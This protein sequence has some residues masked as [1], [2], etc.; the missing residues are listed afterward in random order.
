MLPGL[1]THG[2]L[3]IIS[4]SMFSGKTSKLIELYKK[5]TLCNIPVIVVNH[6]SDNRYSNTDLSTHD[7]Q[8]I[9]CLWANHL[10]ELDKNK[11]V[12]DSRVILINEAQFF[13]D[14][15]SWTKN[16][17]ENNKKIVF[18]CGLDGDYTRNS[19]GNWL[20]LIPLCDEVCKLTALC[21]ACKCNPG[22]F[23]KRLID[24]NEQVL[25]GNDSYIPVCR[26]CYNNPVTHYC[27]KISTS[28]SDNIKSKQ[29]LLF[30]KQQEYIRL[31][32]NIRSTSLLKKECMDLEK[33]INKDYEI[34]KK[35]I[36]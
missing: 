24:N 22:I 2:Y 33:E 13:P 35:D 25:I 14:I 30:K 31:P 15:V 6:N 5:Y 21:A 28:Q 29:K 16:Q 18:A 12:C 3:G 7:G 11:M 8:T 36:K 4:G 26:Y 17:V 19:F 20:D 9:P 10:S 32:R 1:D 34:F 27:S 23:S